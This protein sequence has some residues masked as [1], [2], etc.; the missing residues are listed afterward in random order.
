MHPR[1]VNGPYA[2]GDMARVNT[3]RLA[4]RS[5]DLSIMLV[6]K[7]GQALQKLTPEDW[8]VQRIPSH[9]RRP[10]LFYG[11]RC[12]LVLK[13]CRLYIVLACGTKE[14]ALRVP[15]FQDQ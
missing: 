5:G 9:G 2:S 13:P 6:V 14:F 8:V 1:N 15:S 12:L 7:E 3:E 11:I 4:K 10:M